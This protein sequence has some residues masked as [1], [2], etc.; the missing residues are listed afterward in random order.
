MG[1]CDRRLTTQ[2]FAIEL[3]TRADDSDLEQLFYTEAMSA[4]EAVTIRAPG[5]F[6][7]DKQEQKKFFWFL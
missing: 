2:I 6:N 5:G 3:E 1:L 4:M 7:T